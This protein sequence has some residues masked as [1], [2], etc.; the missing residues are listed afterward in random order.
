MKLSDCPVL[1]APVWGPED[2]AVA[3]DWAMAHG[4]RSAERWTRS[5]FTPAIVRAA[6]AENADPI[7][8][9]SPNEFARSYLHRKLEVFTHQIRRRLNTHLIKPPVLA[10]MVADCVRFQ[11]ENAA[12]LA[13]MRP[14]RVS[15]DDRRAGRYYGFFDYEAA[16]EFDNARNARSERAAVRSFRGWW[17]SSRQKQADKIGRRLALAAY[18]FGPDDLTPAD[19]VGTE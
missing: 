10:R 19:L 18:A 4:V 8:V 13:A 17:D 1:D 12:D 9:A 2:V 6:I 15:W 3:A 5:P 14:R 7:R 11:S 16:A